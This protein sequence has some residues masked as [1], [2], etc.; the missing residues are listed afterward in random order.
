MR[1]RDFNAFAHRFHCLEYRWHALS[2]SARLSGSLVASS[3]SANGILVS[4]ERCGIRNP[5]MADASR[6][7]P[8]EFQEVKP[9]RQCQKPVN[10]F[11]VFGRKVLTSARNSACW[12]RFLSPTYMVDANANI[13]FHFWMGVC[14]AMAFSS[15]FP[16]QLRQLHFHHATNNLH[17]STC[18]GRDHKVAQE[19]GLTW[20]MMHT[21]AVWRNPFYPLN[22][23]ACRLVRDVSDDVV[24]QIFLSIA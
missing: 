24:V 13:H 10:Y 12:W 7:V 4:L 21:L 3:M 5:W 14:H 15:W 17:S 9:K 16:T 18:L 20:V 2:F 6:R 19:N 11:L 22:R 23:Q 1:Q 8:P